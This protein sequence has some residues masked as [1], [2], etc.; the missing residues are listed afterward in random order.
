[1]ADTPVYTRLKQHSRKKR[2][3]FSMPSH[4][5]MRGL[6]ND[7]LN[8]DVTELRDTLNL[9]GKD[10]AIMQANEAL[11]EFYGS[12]S[13][14]I[15]SGGSTLAVQT[16]IFT[17][18]S[19]GDTL[20]AGADCHMS[21]INTCALLGINIRFFDTDLT[22]TPEVKAVLVTSPNYYGVTKDIKSISEA[23][24]KN[25]VMLLVD[26]AHGAHFTGKN[27]LPLSA[28]SLGAD[29]VCQSAHKT[30]NALTGAAYLHIC[31]DTPDTERVKKGLCMFSTSSPS[32]PIA[33]SADIAR[34]TLAAADYTKIIN[35]CKSFKEK[36]RAKTE[37]RIL[38]NND[39]TRLVLDFSEYDITG[40]E[41]LDILSD[42]YGIDAEMAD[43]FNVV[44]IASPY[45]TRRDFK[46][47][48]AAVTEIVSRTK[49]REEKPALPEIPYIAERISPNN[50]LGRKTEKT[51]L[52]NS[53]G[54]VCAATVCV[55]PPGVAVIPMGATVT[56]EA[57]EYLRAYIN[58]GAE[59]VG[60]ADGKI[61]VVTE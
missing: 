48:C 9:Y 52:E 40:F 47:L 13:S 61:E 42:T 49:K 56:K 26:E 3:P 24:R 6:K 18:L 45:N 30:L 5:N 31:S 59:C 34:S 53:I 57:A 19:S 8:C 12:K 4:K 43:L 2:I 23:C 51:D 50:S 22:I 29:M 7:L 17:A 58:Q 27:G 28:V 44:L 60:L 38:E 33:A 16:M 32:Y 21:V 14:F 41:V 20:L 46:K 10:E 37:V 35:E 54:R 1:M 36:L 55:Y 25:A 39:I 15:L 11:S